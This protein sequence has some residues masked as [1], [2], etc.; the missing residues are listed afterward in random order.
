VQ[1]HVAFD[2]QKYSRAALRAGGSAAPEN[3]LHWAERNLLV[4]RK[5][6]VVAQIREAVWRFLT[7]DT[8]HLASHRNCS[9][10]AHW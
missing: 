4:E 8:L 6:P 10:I 2:P 5:A 3:W 7:W 9:F 1:A